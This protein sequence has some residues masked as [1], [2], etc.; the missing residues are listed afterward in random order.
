MFWDESNRLRVVYDQNSYQMQH[1][2]YDAAGERTLKASSKIENVYENGQV[3]A[4]NT[5]MG[6]YTT[7]VSPY[8]VVDANQKY[9]KHYFNG[10]QRVASKIGEQDIAIFENGN[11]YL[12]QANS[13]TAEN[14]PSTD[15]DTLKNKQIT[16]FS[17]YLSK[18]TN[19]ATAKN[20]KINYT[21]YKKVDN[22]AETTSA[23]AAD[24]NSAYAALQYAEIYYYHSDHLGT[25]TFL[26]DFDGNPYQFFLNLPFGETM[27]E[28]H[29]YSGEYTNRY[30]FNGKELDEETG[31]YYYGARYYNPKFSIWLS[32]DPLAEEFSNWNPYNYTM[33]NPINLIDPTGMSPKDTDPPG[34]K[35]NPH[36]IQT[37]NVY[38]P[39]RRTKPTGCTPEISMTSQLKSGLKDAGLITLN[40]LN[41][42]GA[43]VFGL[44]PDSTD[45]YAN[46]PDGPNPFSPSTNGYVVAGICAAPVV[47]AAAEAG[48]IGAG[49]SYAYAEGSAYIANF[50]W[51]SY[52]SKAG[53]DFSMELFANNGHVENVNFGS[54]A[55]AGLG[56]TRATNL[57]SNGLSNSFS[58]NLREGYMPNN[59]N[60]FSVNFAGG[61]IG[62]SID[63]KFNSLQKTYGK[64]STNVML[65]SI[66]VG[67]QTVSKTSA[68][69]LSDEN[70]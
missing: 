52:F 70:K 46:S 53:L 3:E 23:K 33:Q 9:S 26:S 10:T 22:N 30:K 59:F 6:L 41:N 64:G 8:M 12:K 17:Y 56:N 57:I 66:N 43:A 2:I 13:K 11:Q 27:A 35:N 60:Q 62:N 18:S 67:M 28:Q 19:N 38:S 29:S 36:Q 7:Y 44:S 24:N 51:S 50:T 4:N 48:L 14:T 20:L 42:I 63:N 39:T 5:T 65:K 55:F 58:Y 45:R 15:F 21:E 34:S 16:D 47:V 37:V 69:Y 31:F 40:V 68:N 61:L 32:V 54:V 49:F 25:G 1:Y